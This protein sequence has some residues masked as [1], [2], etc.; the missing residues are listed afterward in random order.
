M[1]AQ[2]LV[3]WLHVRLVIAY[4][5][6]QSRA[7]HVPTPLSVAQIGVDFIDCIIFAFPTAGC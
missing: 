1:I 6:T 2:H 5:Y 7:E 4:H 3:G